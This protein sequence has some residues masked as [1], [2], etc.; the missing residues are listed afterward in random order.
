MTQPPCFLGMKNKI[1]DS[2][3]HLDFEDFTKDLDDVITNAKISD[4]EYMLSIS[5]NLEKFDQI[6]KIAKRY[7]NIWCTTGVHPNNVP[8][9]IDCE[10]VDEL[11]N[12]LE[13]NLSKKKVVGIGETGLDY[14]RNL[15]NKN[16][17]IY[18]FESHMEISGKT[19]YPTIIH[20]RDAEEDTIYFLKKAVK[21]YNTKGLIHCFSSGKSLAKCALDN[22]IYISFSGIITFNRA[23]ELGKIVNYVPLD[24]ILVETDS[25]Y[26]APV[27]KR[28]KRNEPANTK[29]VLEKIAQIKNLSA[30]K[31]AE[32]TTDNFFRLF[33][34]AKNET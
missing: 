15:E 13:K 4:V 17:Q 7:N 3:C 19:K 28:G 1:V 31:V 27:P 14:F 29:F 20:T 23:E 8:E 34:R 21:E 11:K 6:Y 26:L 5:V 24:R 30:E 22:D 25:P 33:S 18:F 12:K 16:N 32:V 10:K 2:H 9:K